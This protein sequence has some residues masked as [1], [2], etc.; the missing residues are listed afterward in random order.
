MSRNREWKVDMAIEIQIVFKNNRI[1]WVG[2]CAYANYLTRPCK[3]VHKTS[4]SSNHFTLSGSDSLGVGSN[5]IPY[6]FQ[7]ANSVSS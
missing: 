1:N 2:K 4:Q 5:E 3:Q 6:P 7:R